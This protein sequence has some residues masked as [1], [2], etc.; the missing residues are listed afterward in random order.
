MDFTGY[1]DATEE[2]FAQE[3]EDMIDRV[4]KLGQFWNDSAKLDT[5]S[6]AKCHELKELKKMLSKGNLQILRTREE[7][8]HQKLKN[9]KLRFHVRQLQAEIFR[10]LPYSHSDVPSTEYHM[11]LDRNVYR[12]ANQPQKEMDEEHEKELIQ[13]RQD[14]IDICQLQQ[15]VFAEEVQTLNDDNAQWQKFSNDF[16]SQN[17]DTHKLI[18]T[19][20]GDVT[21]RYVTLKTAYDSMVAAKTESLETLERKFKRLKT[22]S[23]STLSTLS[24]KSFQAR[25]QARLDASQQCN[26]V[27]ERVRELEKKNLRHFSAMKE[28]D[29]ELQEKELSLLRQVE[30]LQTQVNELDHRKQGLSEEGN[31]RISELEAKLNAVMSVAAA[32]KDTPNT[33]E[34]NILNAVSSAMGKHA[35]SARNVEDVHLQMKAMARQLNE[36]AGLYGIEE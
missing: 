1:Y 15:E 36:V 4:D 14:W 18:D 20:L 2:S 21:R 27:R 17:H 35:K 13:L 34:K 24:E 33:E 5:E 7:I 16:Q 26:I 23:E 11:S 22:L 28:K 6:I 9:S 29:N 25:T 10:L 30:K 8:M 12:P 32:I 19:Q 3:K 31:L